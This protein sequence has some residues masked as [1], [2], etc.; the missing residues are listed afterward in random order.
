MILFVVVVVVV[1][2]IVVVVIVVDDVA[3]VIA[4]AVIQQPF[5]S[6]NFPR[7]KELRTA[8]WTLTL[9][10]LMDFN[11]ILSLIYTYQIAKSINLRLNSRY[12]ISPSYIFRQ[13]SLFH[14]RK[15][16]IEMARQIF[17]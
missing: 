11:V 15:L 16:F 12:Y 8:P 4:V 3:V 6:N 9:S 17:L 1:V 7:N 2:I 14:I 5:S 13:I 10:C